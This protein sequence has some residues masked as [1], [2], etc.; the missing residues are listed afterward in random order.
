MTFRLDANLLK[1][2]FS[3]AAST[4]LVAVALSAMKRAKPEHGRKA[5]AVLKPIAERLTHLLN[6]PGVFTPAQ[7][8]ELEN[9]LGVIGDE[10]AIR[11]P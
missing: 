11:A 3:E 1:H 4:Q 10:T 6:G 7:T 2:D 9:A 5:A 8:A